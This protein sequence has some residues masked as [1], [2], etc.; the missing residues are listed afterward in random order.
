MGGVCGGG[1]GALARLSQ[2]N[3]EEEALLDGA[4]EALGAGLDG[5]W[6]GIGKLAGERFEVLGTQGSGWPDDVPDRDLKASPGGKVIEGRGYLA[7]PDRVSELFPED[8]T[9]TELGA[10]SY[11]GHAFLAGEGNVLGH[12]FAMNARPDTATSR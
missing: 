2:S 9:L 10:V 5:R 11:Q 8:R 12:V 6:A 1:A 4:A 3:T 7:I